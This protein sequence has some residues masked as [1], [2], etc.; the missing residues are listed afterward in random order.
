MTYR[1]SD[2]GL[3]ALAAVELMYQINRSEITRRMVTYGLANLEE[4]LGPPPEQ[5]QVESGAA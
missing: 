2:A 1:I 4:V 3:E 5:E